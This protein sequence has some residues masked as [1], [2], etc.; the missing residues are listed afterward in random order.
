MTFKT[1]ETQDLLAS[2]PDVLLSE[3]FYATI[4]KSHHVNPERRLMA[5][6]LEDAVACLTVDPR[7]CSRRRARDFIEARA[8][9]NGAEDNDWVFSFTMV[10]ELLGL[11][12]SFVRKGLNR[13]SERC[14]A[15]VEN[16]SRPRRQA[17]GMRRKQLRLRA[18]M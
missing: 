1:R 4:R 10:C 9:V 2:E 8:W 11:D 3:Q 12:P 15:Q 18:A 6:V 14:S 16:L 13:W 17:A 7:A 5:A